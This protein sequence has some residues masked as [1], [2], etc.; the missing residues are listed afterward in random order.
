MQ[1]TSYSPIS[2]TAT[3]FKVECKWNGC[4]A[5]FLTKEEYKRQMR[6]DNQG[7]RCPSCGDDASWDDDN[8]ETMMGL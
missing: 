1:K 5:F 2:E 3:P 4:G 6:N 8:Y 7:W